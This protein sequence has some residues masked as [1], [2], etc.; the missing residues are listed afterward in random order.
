MCAGGSTLYDEMKRV[1]NYG[2]SNVLMCYRGG[3]RYK[4]LRV[5]INDSHQIYKECI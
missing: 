1:L 5:Q 2:G 4:N 3:V